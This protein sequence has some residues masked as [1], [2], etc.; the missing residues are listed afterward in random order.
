MF[1]SQLLKSKMALNDVTMARLAV[2]IGVNPSTLNRKFKGISEFNRNEILIIKN[3]LNLT[4]DEVNA[5]FFN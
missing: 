2:E 1:E 3:F 5:I 4:A